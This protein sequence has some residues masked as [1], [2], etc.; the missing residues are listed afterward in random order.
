MAIYNISEE[1]KK[2][3]LSERIFDEPSKG[4]D[5]LFSSF[6]ARFF[7]LFLLVID[8]LWAV[9]STLRLIPALLFSSLTLFRSTKFLQKSYLN[10]KRSLV[11]ALALFVTLFSPALGIMFACTY[12]LM[13]DKAG[14]EEVVPAILR[15]QFK[16][17]MN[18]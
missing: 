16:E 10:F 7:F 8:L 14:I 6:A 11:C 17:F 4:K 18:D 9:F 3:D 15:D 5:R 1:Q 2:Q 13:Y 12:F